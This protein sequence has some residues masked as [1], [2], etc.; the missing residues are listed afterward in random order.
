MPPRRDIG[1]RIYSVSKEGGGKTRDTYGRV[2]DIAVLVNGVFSR[3]KADTFNDGHDTCLFAR[4]RSA[5]EFFGVHEL[6][7]NGEDGL[8]DSTGLNILAWRRRESSER[9]LRDTIRSIHRSRISRLDIMLRDD[10]DRALAGLNKILQTILRLVK[11]ARI[12]NHENRRIVVHHLRVRKRRQIRTTPVLRPGTYETDG[13]GYDGGDQQFVVER[14]R[15]AVLVR[16]DVYVVVLQA[17]AVVVC[18]LAGLPRR[19]LGFGEGEL[20]VGSPLRAAGFD[21]FEVAVRIAFDVLSS[22]IQ[23]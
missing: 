22:T 6:A 11:P 21:F 19:V 23:H 5:L 9:P 8:L 10:I 14:R 18:A 20:F 16:V 17:F 2:N 15:P 12:P 1:R 7:L 4:R 13:S 3:P